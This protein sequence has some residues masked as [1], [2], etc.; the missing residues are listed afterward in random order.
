MVERSS[1]WVLDA[2]PLI[3][4]LA[5]GAFAEVL[6]ALERRFVAVRKAVS[7]VRRG[8]ATS[9]LED[10]LGNGLLERGDLSEQAAKTFA[11]L[12][13]DDHDLGDGE[14]ATI[15]HA[16]DLNLGVVLDDGKARRICAARFPATPILSTVDLLRHPRV[17][18]AL[19]PRLAPTIFD[20]L[21]VGRMR[22]LVEHDDW[23]RSLL[24]AE[25]S[26]RCPSLRRR[27][28]TGPVP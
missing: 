21:I 6:H 12:V 13:G 11:E 19:G 3:N 20:A 28:P 5:S 25:R 24:G 16:V 18:L 2:S 7:E 23:V 4:L 22:V 1:G 9:L 14:S 27:T 26:A 8:S 17:A 15:A 10:A